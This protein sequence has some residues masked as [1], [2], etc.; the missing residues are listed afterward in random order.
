[1]HDR[2]PQSV[3]LCSE[4]GTPDN[5]AWLH[6]DPGSFGIGSESVRKQGEGAYAFSVKG[7]DIDNREEPTPATRAFA[8][9]AVTGPALMLRPRRSEVAAGKTFTVELIAEEVSNLM[10]AHATFS[11]EPGPIELQDVHKGD[12]LTSGGGKLGFWWDQSA[13]RT[14]ELTT[15]VGLGD[16]P[17][18]SGR[19]AIAR[20]TF[21]AVSTG[22][23][24]IK[25]NRA[26]LRDSANGS[27]PARALVEGIVT[28]R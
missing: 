26:D 13:P 21:R 16:P 7:R 22:T 27:V 12:F 11:Y 25:I 24:A 23:S 15:G 20:L 6:D 10:L 14:V 18:A 4:L 8:V 9:N 28:V 3:P 17:G 2:H 19:G 5:G 1:V